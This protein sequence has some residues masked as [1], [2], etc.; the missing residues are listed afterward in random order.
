MT[1]PITTGYS[2]TQIALHWAVAALVAAQYLFNDAIA[3]AWSAYVQGKAYGFDPL[4]LAHVAGGVLILA[5]VLWRIAL[6]TTRAAPPLPEREP[7]AL[8]VLARVTHLAFYA[9]L[10]GLSAT[11]ALAWFVDVRPAAGAHNV[12]KVVLLALIALHVLAVIFH[13]SVLKSG[14]MQRMVRPGV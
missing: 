6:R 10:I 14:I 7:P 2:R 5:L 4:V 9:A 1:A 12:L 13:Q 3:E 8:A 11:G